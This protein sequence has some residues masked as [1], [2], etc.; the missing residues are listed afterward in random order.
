MAIEILSGN[1]LDAFDKGEVTCVAHVVNCQGV[2]NAGIAKQIRERYPEVYYAYIERIARVDKKSD[3]LGAITFRYFPSRNNVF[4]RVFNM[5]AQLNY[6][7]EKRHLNYGAFAS[8]LMKIEE[9]M[10]EYDVLG[11]PYLPGCGLA[12]GD[13]EIV[14]ELIKFYLKNSNVRI[15]KL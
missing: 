11:L 1:L 2:F 13:E 14:L 6:G 4:P 3:L 8:C 10:E 7:I 5:F 9:Q 15:Y 12:G